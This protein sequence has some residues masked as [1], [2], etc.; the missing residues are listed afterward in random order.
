MGNTTTNDAQIEHIMN[1]IRPDLSSVKQSAPS[2]LELG[3]SGLNRWGQDIFE[4]FIPLL[5][6]PRSTKV[7]K[8]MSS[9]DPVIGAIL[10]CARQLI[11]KVT[12]HVRP[13]SDKKVDVEAAEFLESCRNDMS[14]TWND[15]IDS[16][17]SSFEYG[18]SYHEI[19]YKKRMGAQK[20]ASKRSKYN[21]GR[22]GWRKISERSQESWSGWEF[23]T[24]DDG[25][26][27][28]MWQ[29][30]HSNKVFIPIEKSLLF[31]TTSSRNN[32]EGRSFLRNAYRPWYFKKH[33]EEIE[34]IGIERDLA[35]LPVLKTPEGLDI[36]DTTNP[37]ANRQRVVAESLVRSIRRDKNE[38][39][40]L[41]FGWDLSLLASGSKRQFD[42]NATINRYDQRI[43]ITLLSDIVMLGADKVGSFALADVKKTLL[44]AALDA[45]VDG[46]VQVFNRY[47]VPRLFDFNYFPGMTDYPT[48]EAS[49]VDSPDIKEIADYIQKLSGCKMPLFPNLDLENYLRSIANLP[50]TT[51]T[52][53]ARQYVIKQLDKETADDSKEDD[54]ED[55]TEETSKDDDKKKDNK[56]QKQVKEVKK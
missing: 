20:D 56:D 35:G 42:T 31:R 22:I 38:G 1:E 16:I 10:L 25:S 18:F 52:D 55:N 49:P 46:S 32:P 29:Q 43:A 11:R 33:I 13:A 54:D 17:T 51:E 23:D 24:I 27:R 28:G 12:W 40:V 5:R 47:A 4:E 3:N 15:L 7:Y 41:P 21:D 45:Q 48:L 37:E 14:M 30:T 9:N 53:P 26:F 19:I 36:W 6:M 2:F 50:L 39:V 44:A 34:G 8:E